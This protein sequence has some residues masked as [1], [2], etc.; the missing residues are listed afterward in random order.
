M[1]CPGYSPGRFKLNTSVTAV[2]SVAQTCQRLEFQYVERPVIHTIV[3]H[4]DSHYLA[5]D[6]EIR[7]APKLHDFGHPAF[8]SSGSAGH[9]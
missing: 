7:L 3:A 4:V 5:K 8:Q 2:V 6:Q 1:D 9:A